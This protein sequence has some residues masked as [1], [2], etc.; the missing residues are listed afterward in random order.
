V[1]GIDIYPFPKPDEDL[2]Q[3]QRSSINVHIKNSS[4]A[5]LNLGSQVGTINAALAAI[6]QRPG[7]SPQELVQAI[8]QL[9]E[10]T[11][12][13]KAL[14]DTEKQE[15]VEALSTVAE[16]AAKKPEER[17]KGKVRAVVSWCRPHWSTT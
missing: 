17:S 8:K 4:V 6:S 9:M 12:A 16:Q 13:D 7:P 11:I 3:A 14:P 2:R 10:A 1:L 15:I 5:N